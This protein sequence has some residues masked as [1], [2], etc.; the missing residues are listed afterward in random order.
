MIENPDK[1]IRKGLSARRNPT[2][3][4]VERDIIIPAGTILRDYGET[5]FG[6]VVGFNT[7]AGEFSISVKL[8][9]KV[10]DYFKAVIA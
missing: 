6:T 4:R 8:G 1:K 10:S 7:T 2:C 9:D 3:Y 5:K